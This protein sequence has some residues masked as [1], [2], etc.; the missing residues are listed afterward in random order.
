MK[1]AANPK[2]GLIAYS[3]SNADDDATLKLLV[4]IAAKQ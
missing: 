3:N 1:L 2:T 4:P